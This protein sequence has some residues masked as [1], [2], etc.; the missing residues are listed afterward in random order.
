MLL[1]L[2]MSYNVNPLH[3][4]LILNGFIVRYAVSI[5]SIY[6]QLNSLSSSYINYVNFIY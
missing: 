2:V 1:M 3:L 5:E 4:H 6:Y